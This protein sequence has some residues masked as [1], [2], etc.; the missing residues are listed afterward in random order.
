MLYDDDKLQIGI[1]IVIQGAQGQAMVYLG[2]KSPEE[3]CDLEFE[4]WSPPELELEI[5]AV[6]QEGPLRTGQKT[7][8]LLS[9]NLKGL[10][11]RHPK[12]AFRFKWATLPMTLVLQLPIFLTRF[13][14]PLKKA[15]AD[16]WQ[17][18]Q[19][20]SST[21]TSLEFNRIS[22]DIKSMRELAGFTSFGGMAQL[23]SASDVPELSPRCL[24]SAGICP[25]AEYI[26]LVEVDA[27]ATNGTI[28]I[29]SESAVMR[30]AMASYMLWLIQG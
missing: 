27:T 8:R 28:T 29:R 16:V 25:G 4:I 10:Y 7:N 26:G 5:K 11:S 12:V 1:Q 30:N 9:F 24:M 18:W 14:T 15:G 17:Q 21:E 19:S 23:Y 2:N 20:L 6:H 3:I 13:L 22:P